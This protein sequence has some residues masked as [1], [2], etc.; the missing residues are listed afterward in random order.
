MHS[1]DGPQKLENREGKISWWL[2]S[3]HLYFCVL[4]NLVQSCYSTVAA[5][6]CGGGRR[7]QQ[8]PV[9]VLLELGLQLGSGCYPS[10]ICC[11]ASTCC[12]CVAPLAPLH[13][14]TARARAHSFRRP[15]LRT[16]AQCAAAATDGMSSPLLSVYFIGLIFNTSSSLDHI[17]L[18]QQIQEMCQLVKYFDKNW[19]RLK[20]FYFLHSSALEEWRNSLR[21][22]P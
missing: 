18:W 15:Q 13:S 9:A 5:A 3:N 14:A 8:L 7:H 10:E 1:H 17:E 2:L 6:H 11:L 16:A 4:F 22:F 20:S 12:F 19:E 21:I